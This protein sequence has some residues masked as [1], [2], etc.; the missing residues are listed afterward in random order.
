MNSNNHRKVGQ[1]VLFADGHVEFVPN[2]FAGIKRNNIYVPDKSDDNGATIYIG[3]TDLK[4]T[5]AK[6]SH[7]Y[8]SVLLPWESDN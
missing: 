7:A 5:N 4:G 3:T 6:S 2:V 8:D 1:N